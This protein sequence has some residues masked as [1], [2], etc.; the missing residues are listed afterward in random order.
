[1]TAP[2]LDLTAA[3]NSDHRLLTVEQAATY[4]A[5]SRARTY[6]LLASGALESVKIGRSRRVPLVALHE[7]V[8]RLRNGDERHTPEAS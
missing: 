5:V 3:A 1:M 2:D 4:L 7:Y 6:E 8:E